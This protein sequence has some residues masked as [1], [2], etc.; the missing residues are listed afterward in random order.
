MGRP[1]NNSAEAPHGK[2]QEDAV[3]ALRGELRVEEGGSEGFV[4]SQADLID[5]LGVE[6]VGGKGGLPDATSG[7]EKHQQRARG[8]RVWESKVS[9]S[10]RRVIKSTLLAAH[11]H[12][13]PRTSSFQLFGFDVLLDQ[14]LAPCE[15]PGSSAAL[16]TSGR[17]F[18]RNCL[19]PTVFIAQPFHNCKKIPLYIQVFSPQERGKF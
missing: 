13:R 7:L 10:I 3:G 12:I 4:A 16:L 1:A 17:E 5:T 18:G 19:R 15:F 11:S 8:Q 14:D 2:R 6:G 9:P